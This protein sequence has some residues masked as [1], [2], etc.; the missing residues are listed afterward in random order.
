MNYL[1]HAALAESGPHSLIGNLA[2]DHVKGPL[3]AHGLDADVARGV[4]RH[5]RVDGLTDSHPTFAQLR[6]RLDPRHRRYAGI[7]L[8]VLFDH[9]RS[10]DWPVLCAGEYDAFIEATY[11]T[12]RGHYHLVPEPFAALLPRW[13]DADWLR[14]YASIDGVD[15]VMQRLAG[16]LSRGERLLAA[17]QSIREEREQFRD[18]FHEIF[19]DVRTA[20]DQPAA[21]TR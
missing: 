1:A 15:A 12:L 16:R 7:V 18:G 14:V 13:V 21:Q 4:R 11:T 8:D 10:E 2:G 6:A 17:W 19:G 3:E 20:L 5:R 9:F